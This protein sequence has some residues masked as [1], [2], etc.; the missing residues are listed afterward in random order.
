MGVIV[1]DRL[2]GLSKS[3][4]QTK[5]NNRNFYKYLMRIIVSIALI[6]GLLASFVPDVSAATPPDG[7]YKVKLSLMKR[8]DEEKSMGDGAFVPTGF[9]TV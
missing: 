6:I 3:K 8:Y 7:I 2:L 1:I 9:I 5:I 4:R